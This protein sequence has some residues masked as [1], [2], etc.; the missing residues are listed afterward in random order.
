MIEIQN[1][2]HKFK[3][4]KKEPGFKASLKSL[5]FRKYDEKNALNNINIHIDEGE[6]VGL[7]GANGAGKTTLIKILS[8]II[9]PSQGTIS[10]LNFDPWK[11]DNRL[12]KQMSLI[13]GQK[14][15]LWWDL[16]AADC[17]LLLKEIYEIEDQ[18]FENDC[19]LLSEKLFITDQ[20]KTPI[21]SLSLGERMKVEL[22][23]SL[24]HRPKIIF[25]DEPT[26]GLDLSSQKAIR[27]FIIEY[28]QQHKPTIIITSHYMED[29]EALCKRVVIV[30]KGNLIYDGKLQHIYER[31]AQTKVLTLTFNSPCTHELLS[32]INNFG[33]I[34]QDSSYSLKL[35]INKNEI[36]KVS[37]ELLKNLE[38]KDL[39]I[40]NEDISEIIEKILKEGIHA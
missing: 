2:T 26:I 6:I 34:Q 16:P 37:S 19:K 29:I 10:I 1:V 40:E 24:L 8:G 11:R 25:L 12:R 27:D 15:Q 5:F 33:H 23:A 32:K 28:H 13:M 22:M 20:L 36:S 3:V 39:S 35:H 17:F 4:A 30:R 38:L 14:A 18:Q 31:F 21:R 9:K 7:I